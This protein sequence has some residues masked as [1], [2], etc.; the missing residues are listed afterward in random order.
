MDPAV[1]ASIISTA[2][3]GIANLAGSS[4]ERRSQRKQQE[5]ARRQ[6]LA[7]RQHNEW[8]N[9]PAQQRERLRQAGLGISSDTV[10]PDDTSSENMQYA[11]PYTNDI[12]NSRSTGLEQLSQTPAQAMKFALDMAEQTSRIKGLSSDND[13]KDITLKYADQ[14]A[15]LALDKGYNELAQGKEQL[16]IMRN[17]AN[18]SKKQAALLDVQIKYADQLESAKANLA[19]AQAKLAGNEVK[20]SDATLQTKIDKEFADLEQAFASVRL[21]QAQISKVCADIS[22]INVDTANAAVYGKILK[23][24]LTQEQLKSQFDG[25]TLEDR[26]SIIGSQEFS[27]ESEAN[28]AASKYQQQLTDEATY[29][30]DKAIGWLSSIV[31]AGVSAFNAGTQRMLV[32]K[33][34]FQARTL[35]DGRSGRPLVTPNGTPL[36]Y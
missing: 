21:T 29:K 11:A 3:A 6:S 18:L 13:L 28:I 19:S 5:L 32:N 8:Y 7:D 26:I 23:E 36:A 20:I 33:S 35:I 27:A 16:I 24:N 17:S 34:S 12:L 2:G 1:T 4:I 22:K 10:K 14:N 9:S 15:R 25:R 30:M 31:G